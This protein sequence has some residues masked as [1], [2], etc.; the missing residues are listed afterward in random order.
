MKTRIISAVVG[1][2]IFILV[3]Y[4][5]PPVAAIAAFAFICGVAAYEFLGET[6]VLKKGSALLWMCCLTAAAIPVLTSYFEAY[7]VLPIIY[8]F[9]L[10]VFLWGI[11]HHETV[12]FEEIAKAY[13]GT[14]IIPY[15]LSSV[16]RIL[17]HNGSYGRIFVLLPF[18]AAWC[19]DTM[20]LT[21]GMICGRHKLAPAISPKKTIEGAVGGILGGILGMLIYGIVTAHFFD[22]QPDFI[23]LIVAGT[24]GAI[25]GQIGDL[26]LSLIKRN[27]GIKDYGKIMPGHGGILDR[28]DSVVFTAPLF[29]VMLHFTKIL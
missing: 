6:K 1:I 15:M 29:E 24:I 22:T 14:I 27:T 4:F 26:S 5:M 25:A 20:A 7:I 23:L 11:F 18:V 21:V 9:T 10:L 13:L 8:A 2:A 12:H 19:S 3:V 28:F 17:V 16:V